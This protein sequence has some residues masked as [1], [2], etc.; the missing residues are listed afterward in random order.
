MRLLLV[1]FAV[2]GQFCTFAWGADGVRR[3]PIVEAV[4]RIGPSVVNISTEQVVEAQ[5][6]PF[7]GFRDPFFD[8][9]FQ[10]F[11]EP[12]R[13]MTRSSLGSGVV[14]RP[15]GYV[16]TN[17]HVILR[18]GRIRVTLS[19]EREFE[20]RL[21]GTDSD[22]DLAVL[23]VEAEDALPAATLGDSGS[24]LIG[25]TVIAIGNPFGLSHTVT[26]GVVSAVGRSLKTENQTFYDFIQT[27]ASINPGNSGGP[28]LNLEGDLIG[29]NTAIYQ[30]AQGI[31]F[32]I[33]ANRAKRIVDDLIRYGEVH[34]P[35]IGA[36]VQNLSEELAEHFGLQRR[37]GVLVR[38]IEEDS[39]AGDAGLAA[40][41]V[42]LEVDGKPVHSTEEYD[43]RVR[44]RAADAE[45]LLSVRREDG[46]RTVRVR[47]RTFP[48]ERAETLA[49]K[50][51]GL[52]VR[53]TRGALAVAEVRRGS[54]AARI[55]ITRGDFLV[56]IGGTPLD[57]LDRFRRRVVDVRNNQSVMVSIQRGQRIHNVQMPLG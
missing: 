42:I 46:E 47:S 15:D 36:V 55:G 27:D 35:W 50:L 37:R 16:V 33:P 52:R 9:F 10:D 41:E 30:K 21:I 51:L 32:A 25:E 40:G 29:I 19:D 44:D 43:Q 14:V 53:E 31:G 48:I 54:A 8:Q 11:F 49:W 39:P 13:R 34:P 38:A 1:F 17:E 26:S 3:S 18:G 45:I 57:S 56:G 6:Q 20:A 5:G 2:V 4:E 7:P 22:S 24:I 28:L 12:R 23:K